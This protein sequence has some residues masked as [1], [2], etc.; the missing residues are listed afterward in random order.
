MD[1]YC[2]YCDAALNIN[3]DD[4]FG[5]EEDIKHEMEC[6]KCNKSFVFT[7]AIIFNYEA[8][9][10]DCLNDG[11]HDYQ[12]SHTSPKA[13]SKMICSMCDDQRELTEDER[14]INNIPTRQEYFK[15]L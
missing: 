13:F 3:H 6:E 10:A 12:L 2:P 8:E 14:I 5:Y 1:L 15:Q 4:G 7:T 11:L 9:K